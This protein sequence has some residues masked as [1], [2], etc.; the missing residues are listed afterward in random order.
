M[1][2]FSACLLDGL[3][4]QVR[5][6]FTLDE[7]DERRL[8]ERRVADDVEELLLLLLILHPQHALPDCLARRR[9]LSRDVSE[10]R[11]RCEV[12]YFQEKYSLSLLF[13]LFLSFSFTRTIPTAMK[14]G[15]RRMVFDRF[16]MGGGMVAENSRV[17]RDSGRCCTMSRT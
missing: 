16:S 15:S 5:A 11:L 7:D 14:T 13:C 1:H 3:R 6:D 8:E 4:E 9:W 12:I 17:C 10:T 2:L